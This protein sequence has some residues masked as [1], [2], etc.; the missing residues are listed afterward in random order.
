[1]NCTFNLFWLD[2]FKKYST[3]STAILFK[4]CSIKYK[5]GLH[6][7]LNLQKKTKQKKQFATA[8]CQ[9][10]HSQ[11][12]KKQLIVML[13]S[14]DSPVRSDFFTGLSLRHFCTLSSDSVRTVSANRLMEPDGR[15]LTNKK[16][17]CGTSGTQDLSIVKFSASFRHVLLHTL[18]LHLRV[19]AK[20]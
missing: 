11:A 18:N 7:S 9:R 17:S 4:T 13:E 6:F 5:P 1:M 12:A 19:K 8:G 15:S 3:S 14:K 16:T 2:L 10:Y 20:Y